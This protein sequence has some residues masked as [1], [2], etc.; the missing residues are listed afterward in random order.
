MPPFTDARHNLYGSDSD[1]AMT[2][3][4]TGGSEMAGLHQ[5]VLPAALA[6]ALCFGCGGGADGAPSSA[7]AS[8]K[9]A[10]SPSSGPVPIQ[11]QVP[12]ASGGPVTSE[13]QRIIDAALADASSRTGTAV[14]ALVVA[15]AEAVVWADGSLG[16]PQPGMAYTMAL[17]PGYRVRIRAGDQLLDYHASGRGNLVLC[18]PGLAVDPA[19]VQSR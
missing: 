18:P 4:R 8:T 5:T 10:D 19:P 15:S 9:A 16:C 1:P 3:I 13:V 11:I 6:G 2:C 14:T 17:V 12:P 7:D